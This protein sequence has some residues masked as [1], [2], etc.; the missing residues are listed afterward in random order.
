MLRNHTEYFGQLSAAFVILSEFELDTAKSL[1][2]VF[3]GWKDIEAFDAR[4]EPIDNLKRIFI[5]D[6]NR[7]NDFVSTHREIFQSISS[8]A[9]SIIGVSATDYQLDYL[10]LQTAKLVMSLSATKRVTKDDTIRRIKTV[11]EYYQLITQN[12]ELITQVVG[13]AWEYG[14]EHDQ[15]LNSLTESDQLNVKR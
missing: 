2:I 14:K 4:D 12:L 5:F 6:G 1:R 7:F 10:N 15:F 13:L 11:P 9:L 3:D 8:A